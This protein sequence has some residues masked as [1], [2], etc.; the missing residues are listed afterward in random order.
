MVGLAADL[1]TDWLKFANATNSEHLPVALDIIGK[2]DRIRSRLFDQVVRVAELQQPKMNINVRES[3]VLLAPD[4]RRG[5]Q[6][7]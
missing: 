2:I 1:E 6:S 3:A 5:G 4:A 7:D